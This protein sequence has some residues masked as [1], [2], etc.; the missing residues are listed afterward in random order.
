MF[1]KVRM[2]T[3]TMLRFQSLHPIWNKNV[4][5]T[6]DNGFQQQRTD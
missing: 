6:Y 5:I 1:E 2:S 4:L 3:L